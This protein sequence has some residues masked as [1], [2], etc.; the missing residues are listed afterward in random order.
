MSRRVLRYQARKALMLAVSAVV[1][2][3]ALTGSVQAFSGDAENSGQN[4]FEAG[5]LDLELAVSGNGPAGKYVVTPGGNGSGG[6]VVFMRLAPGDLGSIT[7]TLLNTGSLPGK[8]AVFAAVTFAENG[9]NEPEGACFGNNEG[10]NGDL[11]ECMG[12]KLQRGAG[13]DPADAQ[14]NF[15]YLAGSNSSY[16][17]FCRLQSALD[18]DEV[19]VGPDGEV[20]T[21]VYKL[22]WTVPSDVKKC[23]PD[24]I[25]DT[26]DDIDVNENII[27]SDSA[28]IDITFAIVDAAQ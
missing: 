20:D 22:S 15:V 12:F 17:A 26:L 18:G 25:L 21:V 6:Q 7:W 5:T 2:A 1:V 24:G 28:W 27:Q 23:G 19:E 10:E 8:L 13:A 11:D 9:S 3:V 4:L 16:A 14:D